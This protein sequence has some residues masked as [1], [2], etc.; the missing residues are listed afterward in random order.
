MIF[1]RKK[2]FRIAVIDII[3]ILIFISIIFLSSVLI[4]IVTNTSDEEGIMIT[5]QSIKHAAVSC[6]AMEG[7]YPE[8]IDYL[9]D[10]YNIVIDT[11]RYIVHYSV[12]GSNLMPDITVLSKNTK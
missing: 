7:R 6:Y 10:N 4:R 12:I 9:L 1:I 5:E 8:D 3:W 11:E 2:R